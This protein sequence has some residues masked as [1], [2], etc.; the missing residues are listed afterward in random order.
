MIRR[1]TLTSMRPTASGAQLHK[2]QHP[3]PPTHSTMAP[4]CSIGDRYP[5]NRSA[6]VLTH[7][8]PCLRLRAQWRNASCNQS[9]HRSAR[10]VRREPTTQI[11]FCFQLFKSAR[12]VRDFGNPEVFARSRRNFCHSRRH[13]CRSAFRRMTTPSA[14]ATSAVRRIAPR[15]LARSSIPSSTTTSGV[16]SPTRSDQIVEIAVL[17]RRSGSHK[18]LDARHF[19]PVRPTPAAIKLAPE[20]QS[21]GTHRSRASSECL[22]APWRHQPTRSCVRAP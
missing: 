8:R 12:N 3:L 13:R 15:L 20:R 17:F 18:S 14:P 10:R 4:G 19:P 7:R 2:A 16:L 1:P 9:R 21:F 11:S 22:C 6:V 5:E